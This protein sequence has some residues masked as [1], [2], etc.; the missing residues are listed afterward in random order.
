MKVRFTRP[1]LNDLKAVTAYLEARHVRERI[2][3]AIER[4]DH[5][6]WIGFFY[7]ITET[8]VIVHAIRHGARG[9]T[10][11]PDAQ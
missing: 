7:E 8:E 6:P 9:S 10:T 2:R 4:L 11:M 1:A 5:Q 3:A